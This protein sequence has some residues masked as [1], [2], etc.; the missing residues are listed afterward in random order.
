MGPG[1][2]VRAGRIRTHSIQ[3]L[4]PTTAQATAADRSAGSLPTPGTCGTR[5]PGPILLES[6]C[7]EGSVCGQKWGSVSL[8][9]KSGSF[10][11][12]H[13]SKAADK[14]EKGRNQ[15]PHKIPGSPEPPPPAKSAQLSPG[16]P[17]G[18]PHVLTDEA[19]QLLYNSCRFTPLPLGTVSA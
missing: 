2:A 12:S 11:V 10:I 15:E 13:N 4:R 6:S 9:R 3:A 8:N 17:E 14:L 7:S 5:T 16:V 18:D 19:A 1:Q